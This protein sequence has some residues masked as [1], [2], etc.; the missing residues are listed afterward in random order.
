MMLVG[1]AV[2]CF[3]LTDRQG[4]PRYAPEKVSIVK[5]CFASA[6]AAPAAAL[7]DARLL[8]RIREIAEANAGWRIALFISPLAGSGRAWE[9]HF[10]A[11]GRVMM[12]HHA[13]GRIA[14]GPI[15]TI[16]GAAA[17]KWVALENRSEMTAPCGESRVAR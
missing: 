3:V 11:G 15:A 14:H 6:K 10:D 16:D 9:D 4:W 13:P 2:R 7:G 8:A 5:R 1:V 17:E 12:V